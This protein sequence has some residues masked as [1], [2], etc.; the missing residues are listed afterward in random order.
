MHSVA[1]HPSGMTLLV[2]FSDKL[3]LMTILMDDLR[4]VKEISIRACRE[5][6]FS[7][8]GQYFAAINGNTIQLYNTYTCE[9]IGNLRGHNGKVRGFEVSFSRSL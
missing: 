6:K 4:T 1:L 3:R 5:C 2:G 8:G 9:N 7:N